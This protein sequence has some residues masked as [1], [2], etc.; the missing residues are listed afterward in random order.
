MAQF[1]LLNQVGNGTPHE[2]MKFLD[3]LCK[4][5]KQQLEKLAS[6]ADYAMAFY[7]TAMAGFG[8]TPKGMEY[9]KNT[10]VTGSSWGDSLSIYFQLAINLIKSRRKRQQNL[11]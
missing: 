3:G 11:Q 4:A 8:D 10:L 9:Q 5:N 6:I 1:N 7:G 2:H